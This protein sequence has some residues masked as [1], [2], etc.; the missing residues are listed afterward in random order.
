MTDILVACVSVRPERRSASVDVRSTRSE[1]QNTYL[2]FG[3]YMAV[4]ST[5]GLAPV[6]GLGPGWTRVSEA[7]LAY[8]HPEDIE[9]I[10]LFQPV[11]R[12]E[13][14]WGVAVIA[15]A[16]D[17]GRRRIFTASYMIIVRGREKGHGKV[18]VEE[19]GESPVAVLEDVIRGVGDRTGEVDPPVEIASDLWYG[20]PANESEE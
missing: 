15:C 19:V 5:I 20:E 11:R 6:P 16:T 2:I 9:G 14:E 3:D 12:E 13:R 17:D 4:N 1:S 18:A 7:L 8:V 10:W